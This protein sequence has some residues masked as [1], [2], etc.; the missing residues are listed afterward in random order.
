MRSESHPESRYATNH[1]VLRGAATSRLFQTETLTGFWNSQRDRV[2]QWGLLRTLGY[3]VFGVGADKVNVRIWDVFE[4]PR[5]ANSPPRS[6]AATFSI[7]NSMSAWTARDL[8]VLRAHQGLSLLPLYPGYF[9]EGDQCAVARLEGTELACV[10]WLHARNN[11]PFAGG[12]PSFLIQ[13]CFTLP[14]HRGRGLYALTLAHACRHLRCN[15]S[16]SPRVFVECSTF[17]FASKRGILKAGFEPVGWIFKA[18]RQSW[19]MARS[20]FNNHGSSNVTR[21]R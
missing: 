13:N 14:A 4:Y 16:Q 5:N 19:A 2:S 15:Q 6:T 8:E 9:E 18:F 21:G 20:R 12:I 7:V 1:A 11:Y 17:N 10:C 3:Y